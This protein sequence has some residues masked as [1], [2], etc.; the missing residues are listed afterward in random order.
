VDGEVLEKPEHLQAMGE[1]ATRMVH[2]AVDAYV[3]RDV[4]LAREVMN[5][6]DI[7]DDLFVR[8]KVELFD[9]MKKRGE[10]GMQLLDTLMIAKYFERIADHAVNIAEWVEYAVTARYKGETL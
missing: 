3:A 10:H 2:K 9:L 1:E 8:T 7:V 4:E 6:D 5:D